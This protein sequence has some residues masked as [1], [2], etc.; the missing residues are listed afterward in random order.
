MQ[1]RKIPWNNLMSLNIGLLL[2]LKT[3]VSMTKT[4][5]SIH[6]KFRWYSQK[7]RQAI[8]RCLKWDL[9][10]EQ[11]ICLDIRNM[12][13]VSLCWAIYVNCVVC[14][15]LLKNEIVFWRVYLA[16]QIN[17]Y[18]IMYYTIKLLMHAD[19]DEE[20]KVSSSTRTTT[21]QKKREFRK[22]CQVESYAITI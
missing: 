3:L 20:G 12:C 6:R 13:C 7:V 9:C 5:V 17:V 21:Q 14:C 15:M 19:T 2:L 1:F 8:E 22:C 4:I 16:L 10:Y 11:T 18:V